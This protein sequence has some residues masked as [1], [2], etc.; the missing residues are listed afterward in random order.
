MKCPVCGSKMEQ[1][2]QRT[3]GKKVYYCIK[4]RTCHTYINAITSERMP[5]AEIERTDGRKAL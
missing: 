5:A 2:E 3:T 4:W 1:A